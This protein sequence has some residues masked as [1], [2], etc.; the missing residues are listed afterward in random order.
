MKGNELL[1]KMELID[2]SYIEAADSFKP[3]KKYS[4]LKKCAIAAACLVLLSSLGFGAFGYIAE[5]KEYKAAVQFF[6]KHDLSTDGLTRG[7]IKKVYRDITTQTFSYSKT[8]EV[9]VNSLS[10]DQVEG[11]EILQDP[12]P[13]SVIEN[14]WIY[15]ENY[16]IDNS[17]PPKGIRYEYSYEYKDESLIEFDKF[18]FEK[19]DGETLIWKVS[20]SEF[21][22][23]S[24]SVVSDGVIIYGS[25]RTLS[26]TQNSYPWIAKISENGKI[27][28]K[29]MVSDEFHYARVEAVLENN[30]NSY[31][32]FGIGDN[33]YFCFNKYSPK[34]DLICHKKTEI[35]K[36]Y[37]AQVKHLTD[38]YVA[39][40][41]NYDTKDSAE[42]TKIDHEGNI[43]E[44]FSYSQDGYYYY[45]TD[46]IEY[47]GKIYLSAYAVPELADETQN[48]GGRY[49]IANILNN[50][51][52]PNQ[53]F[54][55]SE[56]FTD[57]VR[58]NYT[59]LLLVCD[60]MTGSPK[61]F[62]SVK[63]SFGGK[64]AL[65]KSG[66]LLWNVETINYAFFSPATS[67]FSIGGGCDVFRYTFDDQGILVN[68]NK[69]DEV[70]TFLK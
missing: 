45:I 11:Y 61:E 6:D 29:Q 22:I 7:E 39:Q 58:E 8:A 62:Y 13:P 64:L 35:G 26:T 44:N 43:T 49:E 17:E 19:Y 28:W 32:V 23:D 37:I 63:D 40:L 10:T 46:M 51:M 52:N 18:I 65:S 25:T 20:V 42:I 3:N 47:G 2:A 34:G 4:R 66:Q 56:W 15:K 36:Y 9:I 67:S 12:L 21:M 14:I 24:Y 38:G 70:T 33:K 69:T 59:A 54:F 27:L 41:C 31:S 50:T 5:A 16:N 57:L 68:R 30:D 48:A 55:S 60:Q 53:L 1:D